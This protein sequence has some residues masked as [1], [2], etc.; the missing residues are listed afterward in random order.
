MKY[1]IYPKGKNGILLADVISQIH[2]NIEIDFIDDNNT[3][4]SI[5]NYAKKR[6][7]DLILIASTQYKLNIIEKLESLNIKNYIDGLSLYGKELNKFIISNKK[8]D[9]KPIAFLLRG[10]ANEKHLS[11]LDMSLE[12][13]GYEILYICEN[14]KVLELN[15]KRLRNKLIIISGHELLSYLTEISLFVTTN[16]GITNSKVKSFD[17]RHAFCEPLH[18]PYLNPENYQIILDKYMNNVDYICTSCT[19]TFEVMNMNLKYLINKPILLKAGSLSLDRYIKLVNE[20][21][22][23]F[24]VK[25]KVIVAIKDVFNKKDIIKLSKLLISKNLKVIFRTHPD[26]FT[27]LDSLEISEYFKNEKNFV[28][29]KNSEMSIKDRMES[30]TLITDYS[31]LGYTYPLS[32]LKFS[33]IYNPF[34]E[35]KKIH[36]YSFFDENIHLKANTIDDIVS[37]IENIREHQEENIKKIKKYREKCVF[38]LEKSE[39]FILNQIIGILKKHESN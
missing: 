19:N 32:T 2:P 5:E 39:E 11:K 34:K 36:G 29:D 16:G 15:K 13:Y 20:N 35:E 7:N 24:E 8:L 14:K 9:K 28:F 30:L 23:N 12:E 21:K 3:E 6:T 17:V 10:L 31:S 22:G 26:F 18:F 25:N 1:Y 37:N 4:S 27:S 38:N 33:I